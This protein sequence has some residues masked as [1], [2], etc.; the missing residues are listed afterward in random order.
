[1]EMS[2]L[3]MDACDTCI[4][5]ILLQDHDGHLYPVAY[6]SKK[7]SDRERNYSTIERECLAIVWSIKRF[8]LFLYGKEF[9]LQTDHQPLL[10]L[11]K[12]KFVND[13]V[14]RRA[15]FLQNHV[16]SGSHKRKSE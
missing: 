1:M 5:A 14:M 6:A 8:A 10:Y 2:I 9:I 3:R 4:E 7:L 16:P 11:Q 13:T 12:T 15:L